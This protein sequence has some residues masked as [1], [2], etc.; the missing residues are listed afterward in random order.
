[1]ATLC[2]VAPDEIKG[3]IKRASELASTLEDDSAIQEFLQACS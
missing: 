3:P 1:M 2:E